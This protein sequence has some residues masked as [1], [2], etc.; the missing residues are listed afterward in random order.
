MTPDAIAEIQSITGK[1]L[2]NTLSA[3]TITTPINSAVTKDG[4][5]FDQ[6]SN[7]LLYV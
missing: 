6:S 3:I 4:S 1:K 2:K 5:I 7:I